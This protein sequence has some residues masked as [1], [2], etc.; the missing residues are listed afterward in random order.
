V[1][2]ELREWVTKQLH[3]MV[4]HFG[5]RNAKLVAGILDERTDTVPWAVYAMLGSYA[6]A[7]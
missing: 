4:R 1:S 7:A 5:I 2:R 3:Y 6:F